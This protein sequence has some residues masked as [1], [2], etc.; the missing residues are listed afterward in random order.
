MVGEWIGCGNGFA[1]SGTAHVITNHSV[2]PREEGKLVIPHVS[3]QQAAVQEHQSRAAPRRLISNSD[4][5]DLDASYGFNVPVH[6]RPSSPC[7]ALPWRRLWWD[8]LLLILN[9]ALPMRDPRGSLLIDT[10]RLL[11]FTS[12]S[13]PPLNPTFSGC[14]ARKTL[15][16]ESLILN[17]LAFSASCRLGA[18]HSRPNRDAFRRQWVC[19]KWHS[20]RAQNLHAISLEVR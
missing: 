3:V 6:T 4:P 14:T 11:T 17:N 10:T 7:F 18:G 15:G 20:F 5:R 19:G 1:V 12:M 2:A 16:R 13:S 8:E 9:L